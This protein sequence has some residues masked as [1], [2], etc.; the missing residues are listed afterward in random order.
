LINFICIIFL[1]SISSLDPLQKLKS[2]EE[3]LLESNPF[4]SIPEYTNQ[5]LSLFPSLVNFDRVSINEEM[6]KDA[7]NWQRL[8]SLPRDSAKSQAHVQVPTVSSRDEVIQQAQRRWESVKDYV[9]KKPSHRRNYGMNS[10]A[11]Q[12]SNDCHRS[13]SEPRNTK[14]TETR[15][16]PLGGGASGRGTHSEVTPDTSEK[17][18]QKEMIA[19]SSSKWELDNS[20]VAADSK[21]EETASIPFEYSLSPKLAKVAIVR[22]RIRKESQSLMPGAGTGIQNNQLNNVSVENTELSALHPALHESSRPIL[23]S[24][25]ARSST[26]ERKENEDSIHSLHPVVAQDFDFSGQVE[27]TSVEWKPP[28]LLRSSSSSSIHPGDCVAPARNPRSKSSCNV[29]TSPSESKAREMDNKSQIWR[30]DDTRVPWSG[31]LLRSSSVDTPFQ[32]SNESSVTNITEMTVPVRRRASA[33]VYR[34]I[35]PRRSKVR[36]PQCSTFTP[37]ISHHFDSLLLLIRNICLLLNLI[38]NQQ[39]G[40][41]AKA[42]SSGHF[43]FQ[44]PS[45]RFSTIHRPMTGIREK[46]PVPPGKPLKRVNSLSTIGSVIRETVKKQGSDYLMEVD[47]KTLSLYGQGAL[48]HFLTVKLTE[49]QHQISHFSGKCSLAYSVF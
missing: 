29:N 49:C 4:C 30:T 38:Y 7:R 48:K 24:E 18:S 22:P 44:A 34:H 46:D 47:G 21:S 15:F 9:K 12:I 41:T 5:I 17:Q 10:R 25:R 23:V 19:G 14:Q 40:Q 37:Y 11:R 16:E 13:T 8:R 33:S 43:Q 31:K 35:V 20:Q 3:L 27:P 42:S 26:L 6:R 45:P 32:N 39:R 1:I 28:P 36:S 2:L